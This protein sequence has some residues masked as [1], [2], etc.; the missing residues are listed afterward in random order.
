M[1]RVFT[2]QQKNTGRSRAVLTRA[3]LK[4]AMSSAARETTKLIAFFSFRSRQGDFLLM[5]QTAEEHQTTS[6]CVTI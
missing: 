1:T 5:V 4:A 6:V 3:V 2:Q